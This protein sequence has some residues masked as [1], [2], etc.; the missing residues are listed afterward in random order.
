MTATALNV[1]VALQDEAR[2]AVTPPR[3]RTWGRRGQTP[4]ITVRGRSRRRVS[5]TA[6]CC[7]RPGERSRLIYRPRFHSLLKGARKSFAWQDYR[8]LLVRAHLQLGTPI[9]VVCDINLNT[10]RA[11]GM[12]K[13]AA[14]HEWLTVIQ[15]P[16][17][18]PDLN[19]VKD[20]W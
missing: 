15:L 9:V 11:A 2:F 18:S 10:H 4:V 6:L 20:I 1:W 19:P 7:H 3:A 16:S 13:H 5:V 12:R 14:D 17:Y 8:D